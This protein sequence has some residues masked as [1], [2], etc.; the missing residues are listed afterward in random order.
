MV[1]TGSVRPADIRRSDVL[2]P[3]P[4]HRNG[5]RTK[6]RTVSAD[7]SLI[8]V[9]STL[10]WRSYEYHVYFFVRFDWT[11]CANKHSFLNPYRYIPHTPTLTE[12]RDTGPWTDCSMVLHFLD[13]RSHPDA[14]IPPIRSESSGDG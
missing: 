3:P 6:V 10:Y 2:S 13:G 4:D 12:Y 9:S 14:W 7:V 11:F 1:V 5:S 8:L